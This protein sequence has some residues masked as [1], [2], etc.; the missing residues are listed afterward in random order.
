[1]RFNGRMRVRVQLTLCGFRWVIEGV[2]KQKWSLRSMD[3]GGDRSQHTL[4]YRRSIRKEIKGRRSRS[5]GYIF[6]EL[7]RWT[8]WLIYGDCPD[9]R[10]LQE[11][12]GSPDNLQSHR[13]SGLL[14][15]PCKAIIHA[16]KLESSSPVIIT[17]LLLLLLLAVHIPIERSLS[18]RNNRGERQVSMKGNNDSNKSGS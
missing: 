7:F 11:L 16:L 17:L 9:M 8:P 14:I 13:G 6:M 3:W 1:M 15:V 12:I 5:D 10:A 2:T 4:N 18:F